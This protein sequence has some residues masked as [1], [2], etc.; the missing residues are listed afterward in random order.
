MMR[1]YPGSDNS[2]MWPFSNDLILVPSSEKSIWISN[3]WIAVL[4]PNVRWIQS[5]WIDTSSVMFNSSHYGPFLLKLSNWA[6]YLNQVT[7]III[8]YPYQFMLIYRLKVYFMSDILSI[9][10]SN[11]YR[12]KIQVSQTF[13]R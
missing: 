9:F 11:F 1:A 13:Y 7:Q 3:T 6:I 12:F 10:N 4:P 8:E 2:T 5:S